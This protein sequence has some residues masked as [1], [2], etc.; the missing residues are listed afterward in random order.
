MLSNRLIQ[1]TLLWFALMM[2][3]GCLAPSTNAEAR[4]QEIYTSDSPLLCAAGGR[5]VWPPRR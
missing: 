4:A 1:Y 5:G 3:M 2:C